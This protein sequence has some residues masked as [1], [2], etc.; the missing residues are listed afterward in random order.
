MEITATALSLNV[1]AP[2]ASA[3]F[4]SAHLGF[5]EQMSADGFVSLGHPTAGVNVVYLRTGLESFKPEHMR[6]HHAD[7]LLLAFVVPDVDAE[8]ARLVAEGV[9]VLTPPETEPWGERYLQ[10]M[11]PNGVVV[12][13]VTWVEGPPAEAVVS[14]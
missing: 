5:T 2:R 11:D 9:P 6:G 13:L 8:H 10:V 4:L 14:P 12:Q 3:D 7:G 1:A